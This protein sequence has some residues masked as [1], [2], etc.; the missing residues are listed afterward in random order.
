MDKAKRL[1]LLEKTNIPKA[2]LM[3]AIPT[4]ISSLVM[5]LYNLADTYFVGL[6]NSPIETSA[7]TLAAPVLLFFN[8]VINFSGIGGSSLTSRALGKKDY[9]L[10]KVA[11]SFSFYISLVFGILFSALFFILHNPLLSLLGASSVDAS[12]TYNYLFWTTGLGAT[13]SIIALVLA[14][15]IRAEGSSMHASIGTMLGCLLNIA[16]DPIFILP[17]GLNMGAS[18][19]GLATLISNVISCVYMLIYLLINKKSTFISINIK[20]LKNFKLVIRD[21]FAVGMPAAIQNALNVTSM[22]VLNNFIA[23][24]GNEAVSAMGIAYKINMIPMYICMGFGQGIMPLISYNFA[25]KSYGRM[26]KTITFSLKIMEIMVIVFSVL[27][28]ILSPNLIGAFMKD[29]LVVEYGTIYLRAMCFSLPFMCTGFVAVSTSQAIGNGKSSLLF[30]VLRKGFLE[31]PSIVL[32]NKLIPHYGI[33]YSHLVAEVG[34]FVVA[35]LVL[36]KIFRKCSE[37]VD[38]EYSR[39]K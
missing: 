20:N 34:V 11:T 19:A 10:A 18:G 13:P 21:I 22:I 35:I 25:S 15:L 17:F 30:A 16:L 33:A 4:I 7:V 8:A 1:E 26:K 36:V 2:T 9:K 5:V 12:S 3:L 6:L 28:F 38:N 24:Y 39:D 32:L 37:K 14:Y 29:T 31:I 23:F 27:Y